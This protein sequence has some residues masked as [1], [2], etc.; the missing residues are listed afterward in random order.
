MGPPHILVGVAANAK[1]LK[2]FH[3]RRPALGLFQD[4]VNRQTFRAPARPRI[5][6]TPILVPKKYFLP[7]PSRY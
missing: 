6:Y 5:S 4:V 2:I 7:Q 3:D 1:C